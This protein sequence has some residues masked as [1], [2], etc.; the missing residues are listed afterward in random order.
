M[1]KRG[2]KFFR[3]RGPLV[4][5]GDKNPGRREKMHLSFSVRAVLTRGDCKK[6]RS[7]REGRN[8]AR[9]GEG[10]PSFSHRVGG[11]QKCG[12][13]GLIRGHILGRGRAS[14]RGGGG[15]NVKSYVLESHGIKNV[16][17]RGGS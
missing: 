10:I 7:G 4:L 2:G 1:G 14:R 15:K 12:R 13:V 8:K 17:P 5:L 6:Q 11:F 16:L 9:G 3:L